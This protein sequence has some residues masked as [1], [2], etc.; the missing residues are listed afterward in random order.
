VQLE[1]ETEEERETCPFCEGR[2]DQTPPEV[3][4]LP[5]GREPDTPGW[6]VRVVPNKFPAFEGQEVVVHS[7]EHIRSL[8]DLSDD[9]L[10]LVAHAWRARAESRR[11]E[12]FPYFF[13]CVNEGKLAGSSL[14]HSHSQLVPFRE[15][16]PVPAA[17]HD[18]GCRVCE[19]VE[20]ERSEGTRLVEEDAGLVLFCPY[21]GRAP[22]ECMIAPVEHETDAFASALLGR[23]LGIAADVLRRLAE[24]RG[25]APANLWLHGAGHWH[26]EL[27]PRLT[28]FA[29]IEL[30]AGP[31]VNSLAPEQAAAALRR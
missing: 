24:L 3:F 13:A 23:A 29:G 31:Y 30:G 8:A 19:Y 9:Q 22:Y 2:E 6:S 21:A 17:E 25:P 16:P 26:L 1:P 11:G 20:Q 12:G 10:E 4:A 28:V 14:P 18:G 15:E 5:E 7:P 27:L